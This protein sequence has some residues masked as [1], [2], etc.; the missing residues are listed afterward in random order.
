MFLRFHTYKTIIL[1][2]C[3]LILGVLSFIPTKVSA[4]NLA[5]DITGQYT[6]GAETAELSKVDD[7][8]LAV[9][10]IIKEI[11]KLLGT[12]FLAL[13]V[14]AG[15]QLMT[16]RGD[17]GKVEKAQKTI[18]A[19]VIGLTVILA[20]YSITAFVTKSTKS[21]VTGEFEQSGDTPLKWSDL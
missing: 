16:A 10:G 15:F 9:A 12:I 14:Y 20:A 1:S 8:R 13:T 11:L 2:L 3:L 17:E 5:D 19:A 6:R 4:S 7:P 21:A 18:Q